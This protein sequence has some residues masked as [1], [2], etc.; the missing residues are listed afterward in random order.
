M[1]EQFHLIAK[2]EQEA[3]LF[4][5]KLRFSQDRRAILGVGRLH[6]KLQQRK[7]LRLYSVANSE[8]VRFWKLLDLVCQ[9]H[10]ELK[11]LLGD[12]FSSTRFSSMFLHQV[13][14]LT[15]NN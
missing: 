13:N 6:H 2:P 10:D 4:N 12:G 8:L 14:M 9:P 1:V 3:H 15:I 11:Q 5:R 7:A